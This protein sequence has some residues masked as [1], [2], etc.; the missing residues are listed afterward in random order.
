PPFLPTRRSSDFARIDLT[1]FETVEILEIPISSGNHSSPFTTEN[2]EY[3][4][5]GTRF[6]VPIPQASIPIDG[7]KFKAAQS[8]ISV[9]KETGRMAVAFQILLPGF[10]YDKSHCGKGVSRD[11][12]FFSTYNVEEAH[13]LKEVNSSQRD[14]DYIAAINW[15]KAEACVEQGKFQEVAGIHYNN[16]M[17]EETQ[18]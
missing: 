6:S 8:F 2:G 9:N 14:K 10:D 18:T 1:T 3:L 13:T 5:A 15:K 11:W 16:H 4:V 12:A 7:R 17:D